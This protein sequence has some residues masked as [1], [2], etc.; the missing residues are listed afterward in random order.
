MSTDELNIKFPK[1]YKHGEKIIKK[2]DELNENGKKILSSFLGYP[3][4][5][6]MFYLYLFKKYKSE[7]FLYSDNPEFRLLGLNF[8]VMTRI[9]KAN[10][11]LF[12]NHVDIIAETFV[13]C[14]EKGLKTLII[15][16]TIFDNRGVTH[17]NLL[18]YRKKFHQFEHFEPHGA[19]YMGDEKD[20]RKIKK[21]IESFIEK[22]NTILKN[23][24]L[25][26]IKYIRSE[27]VC[28][29]I[30]GL[31]SLEAVSTLE[32]N[33]TEDIGYCISWNMFFTELCLSNPSVESS[34]LLEV[35]FEYFKDKENIENYLRKVI[36]GY[37]IFIEEKVNKYLSALLGQKITTN[38]IN[39]M[40]DTF[41]SS[42]KK[43]IEIRLSIIEL[44]K[45]ETQMIINKDFNLNAELKD[46]KK[47]LKENKGDPQLLI[48]KKVLENYEEYNHFTPVTSASATSTL[49]ASKIKSPHS[50]TKK[51]SK[52]TGS[53][54]NSN[55]DKLTMRGRKKNNTKKGKI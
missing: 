5:E 20:A 12:D 7:C 55:E 1:P 39:K 48:K 21:P 53:G 22:V 17:A 52:N 49:S 36:R 40:Y 43:V 37:T 15:P 54:S 8:N 47:E 2:L 44:L 41:E 23:K 26:E 33:A 19:Y 16:V 35:A 38:K 11:K 32:T 3:E 29:S 10:K 30:D 25:S 46:I 31:Q 34:K 27:E 6:T 42:Y 18:V 50:G 4:I 9:S 28:P 45:L 14:L 24:G 13:N 51:I